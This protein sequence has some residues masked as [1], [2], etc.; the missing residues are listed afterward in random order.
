MKI[1]EQDMNILNKIKPYLSYIIVAIVFFFIGWCVKPVKT[2]NQVVE[3]QIKGDVQT[4]TE[5]KIAYIPKENKS[6]SDIDMNIGKPEIKVS[7]NGKDTTITKT[8]DEKYVFDKNKMYMTQES[9]LKFDVNVPV[10][11]KT[12]YWGIKA[13]VGNR[14]IGAE[15]DFPINKKTG[16]YGSIAQVDNKKYVGI[17][18]KF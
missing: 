3:K 2:V 18:I 10:Q 9:K 1:G 14:A 6:D 16:V 15:L 5:T 11:D 7:V 8:D 12:K 17:G 4:V 13:L